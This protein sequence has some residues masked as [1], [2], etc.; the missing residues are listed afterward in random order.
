MDSEGFPSI[1]TQEERGVTVSPHCSSLRTRTAASLAFAILVALC[2]ASCST[3]PDISRQEIA[4]DESGAELGAAG[5]PA[6]RSS[7]RRAAVDPLQ[8]E[9]DPLTKNNV[10]FNL[11]PISMPAGS[12]SSPREPESSETRGV[13]NR[14]GSPARPLSPQALQ[15][16]PDA[17]LVAELAHRRATEWAALAGGLGDT[18][19]PGGDARRTTVARQVLALCFLRQDHGAGDDSVA[20]AIRAAHIESAGDDLRLLAAACSFHSGRTEEAAEALAGVALTAQDSKKIGR[21][22]DAE[23]EES[24][25]RFEVDG[26]SF[27]RSIE[28]PGKFTPA[29]SSDLIP[30]RQVLVYGEFRGFRSVKSEKRGNDPET[31]RRAFSASLHVVSSSGEE[32]DRLEFLP[33]SRGMQ[34]T[35]SADDVMNFWA[36]YRVPADLKPGSYKLTVDA[37]D[38]LGKAESRAQIEFEIASK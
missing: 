14:A 26:L 31:Y 38:I 12:S 2:A 29:D 13:A 9:G 8:T 28:G 3:A 33:E 10:Y 32:V 15:S 23:P 36:R 11:T 34:M 1:V 4:N 22:N 27:A 18:E 20:E 37:K 25:L 19:A 24:K 6:S 5:S 35:A 16:V 30:G 17:A 7:E 21:T